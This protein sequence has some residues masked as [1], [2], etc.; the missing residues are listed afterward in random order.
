MSMPREHD[1]A[2]PIPKRPAN[3]TKLHED[4]GYFSLPKHLTRSGRLTAKPRRTRNRHDTNEQHVINVTEERQLLDLYEAVAAA[5]AQNA[6]GPSDEGLDSDEMRQFTYLLQLFQGSSDELIPCEQLEQSNK[7]LSSPA[8]SV[9]SKAEPKSL[10]AGK[11]QKSD[12]HRSTYD[13]QTAA[14][15]ESGRRGYS[16]PD[17]LPEEVIVTDEHHVIDVTA[18]RKLLDLFE[19]VTAA[20]T[21]NARG[22]K[23]PSDEGLDY[24]EMRRFQHLLFQ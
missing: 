20:S 13:R 2:I 5:S 19:A 21:Q 8:D 14:S 4:G 3:E 12:L 24:D 1:D 17:T 18:E 10:R 11:Q 15:V 22:D 6:H 23:K 9:G 16:L 7:T